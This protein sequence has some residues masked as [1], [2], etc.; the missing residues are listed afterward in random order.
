MKKI[1]M[2]LAFTFLLP[3]LVMA[4]AT[5]NGAAVAEGGYAVVSTPAGGA[6]FYDFD[7]KSVIYCQYGKC[8]KI[9]LE[10]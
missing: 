7:K 2:F 9:K 8:E 6:Y 4:E 10:D 3:S 1:V 5:S